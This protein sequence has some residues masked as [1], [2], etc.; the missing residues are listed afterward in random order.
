M[1]LRSAQQ[2]EDEAEKCYQCIEDAREYH[3]A[4]GFE[5]WRSDYPMQHILVREGFE[6]CGLIQFGGGPRLAYEWDK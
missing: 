2:D 1:K 3:K 6:Y 5:Q 4:S